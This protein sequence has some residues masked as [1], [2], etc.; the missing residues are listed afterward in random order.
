MISLDTIGIAVDMGI[1][2]PKNYFK[3]I[4]G[5]IDIV[6]D[7]GVVP[8]K[9]YFKPN[10]EEIGISTELAKPSVISYQFN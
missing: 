9:N 2:P 6:M 7:M 10:I 3:Q 1:I 8:L 5:S 4:F